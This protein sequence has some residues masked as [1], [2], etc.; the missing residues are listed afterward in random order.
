MSSICQS[1]SGTDHIRQDPLAWS[2]TLWFLPV[3]FSPQ[4]KTSSWIAIKY[5][6]GKTGRW[7]E[8]ERGHNSRLLLQTIVCKQILHQESHK[9]R[10]HELRA[11]MKTARLENND[12]IFNNHHKN[13]WIWPSHSRGPLT[14]YQRGHDCVWAIS[15][16]SALEIWDIKWTN[17]TIYYTI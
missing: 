10:F 12:P 14:R 15:L 1:P 11:I 6:R 9:L 17:K 16:L 4:S 5:K 3:L 8:T 13:L 7:N 2:Q